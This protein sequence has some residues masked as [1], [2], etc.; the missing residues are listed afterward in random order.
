MRTSPYK[1]V[2]RYINCLLVIYGLLS[3]YAYAQVV[4]LCRGDSL[5]L[6]LGTV[7]GTVQW[8]SS[9]DMGI[10]WA[11]ISGADS[12]VYI[13]VAPAGVWY[14]AVVVDG[15][16]DPVT[17]EIKKI[18]YSDLQAHAGIDNTFCTNAVPL[19]GFN[20]YSGGSWPMTY[21]WSPA[22]GLSNPNA[23]HPL[24]SPVV[25]TQYVLQVTDAAGCTARDTV[26]IDAHGPVNLPNSQ[27]FMGAFSIPQSFTVPSGVT[28]VV[29]E[30]FGGRG[31]SKSSNIM[32]GGWG[33]SMR[34]E[35]TV[36]PGQ[37][38]TV[39]PGMMGVDHIR[40]PGGG[41]GSGVAIGNTPLIIAGGGGG[42]VPN[43]Y[44]YEGIHGSLAPNGNPG[45]D[46][47]F[48]TPTGGAGGVS[49][50]NGSR[51]LYYGLDQWSSGG[52][53]WWNSTSGSIGDA[54]ACNFGPATVGVFGMGG[55][56]GAGPYPHP[57][58]TGGGGGGGGYSGG[59]A[60]EMG[61]AGGGGGSYNAGSNQCN[62]YKANPTQGLVVIY[63]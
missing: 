18:A 9:S 54:G 4:T 39:C 31:G 58:Q 62:S 6:D 10:S 43:M 7:S 33:T 47:V 41:G 8:E 15:T 55:G 13:T 45:F 23:A 63:W 42:K 52:K 53:G 21:T 1:S 26:F 40:S 32:D 38:L 59:G 25:P 30:V 36:S 35:F 11:V 27:S 28:S 17:S 34:G 22:S 51:V 3:T 16:C 57:I 5:R 14:R 61:S 49:G 50:G 44:Q 56:G 19:G 29:I 20:S 24:A 48:F 12:A 46:G 60:G 2:F 37:V